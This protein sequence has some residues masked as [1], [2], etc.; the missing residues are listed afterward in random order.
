M[1]RTQSNQ[2]KS[3]HA[4]ISLPNNMRSY[5]TNWFIRVLKTSIINRSGIELDVINKFYIM[6]ST[7]ISTHTA[8]MTHQSCYWWYT[9]NTP[10]TLRC[11][12]EYWYIIDIQSLGRLPIQFM[13]IV[14][15]IIMYRTLCTFLNKLFMILT[16]CILVS[17]FY[18]K[19]LVSLPPNC[20]AIRW[21][22]AKG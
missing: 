20:T 21:Q 14:Y 9:G 16:N 22:N 1:F 8:R 3:R 7:P 19:V 10:C 6:I 13:C 2:T 15:F 17:F 5:S 12:G 11:Y 4:T 18:M